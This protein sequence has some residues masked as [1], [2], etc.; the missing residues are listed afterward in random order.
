MVYCFYMRDMAPRTDRSIRNIPVSSAHK[1]SH[2]TRFETEESEGDI[3]QT[4]RR[5][6]RK[7]SIFFIIAAVVVVVV[8]I[9]GGLLLST[10]FSGASVVIRQR[11]AEI[12][13]PITVSALPSAPSGTLAYQIM[14]VS[15]TATTSVTAAG[16]QKVSRQ[17]SG[18]I[19][20]TNNFSKDTQRLIANTRF[21]APDGKI[22]RIHDSVVVPGMA[23][24]TPGTASVSIYADSPG[25][26][27]NR[28]ATRFTIPGF[29]GDPRYTK[30]Y[31]ETI[32]ISGGFV[33]NEPAVAPA[34][35]TAAKL[36]MQKKLQDE[37]RTSFASQVPADSILVEN[38][39]QFVFGDVRQTPDSGKVSLSQSITSNVAIVKAA[40]LASETAKGVEGYSG[41]SVGF[42]DI[43]AIRI[44]I[45][46]GKA[47][48]GKID[49]TVTA[50]FTLVWQYDKAA[51]KQA[52]LGKKKSSFEPIISSFRPALTGAD[53]ILRPFWKSNL[54]SDPNKITLTEEALK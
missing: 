18:V 30:F 2:A 31:A 9:M 6:R 36:A 45:P 25:D 4:P 41:E 32:G 1:K 50:P 20:I 28:G 5:R 43:S 54:P 12:T 22:Y 8:C 26:S 21:E 34:D 14:T 48:L 29:K 44:S 19:T 51:L 46:E 49:I 37:V 16:T 17:A 13:L 27:Y 53:L 52:L 7:K 35:L 47:P 39:F 38:S 10:L 40:D 23:A 3:P 42:K 33:G 15:S 11:T 24:G